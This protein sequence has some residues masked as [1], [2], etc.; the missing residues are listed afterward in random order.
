VPFVLGVLIH[1]SARRGVRD[2]L[3]DVKVYPNTEDVKN[4]IALVRPLNELGLTSFNDDD[5]AVLNDILTYD[6]VNSIDP[7]TEPI[8]KSIVE[9]SLNKSLSKYSELV[10]YVISIVDN[11]DSRIYRGSGFTPITIKRFLNP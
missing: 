10:T 11:I 9:K 6:I 5:F 3:L 7:L 8:E 2:V 1:H 4:I